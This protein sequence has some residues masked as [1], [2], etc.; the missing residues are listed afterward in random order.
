MTTTEP[1]AT[2]RTRLSPEQRREQIIA[3]AQRLYAVQPYNQVSTSALAQEAGVT[4]GLIHHYFGDKREL[5]LAAMR[6]SIVMPEPDLPYFPDLPTEQ[7]VR[8]VV[9]WILDAA[10][11]YG[12]TWLN[13]SGAANLHGESDVQAIIDEADERAARLTLD[14]IGLPDSAH[15]RNRLRALPPLFKSVGREW[16]QRHTMTREEA[17]TLLTSTVLIFVE[18]TR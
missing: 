8:L 7:R 1:P 3:A 13:A 18:E 5:F 14:A 4:R 15:L 16:L 9:E 12:Q 2:A 17:A 6:E 10:S 11:H